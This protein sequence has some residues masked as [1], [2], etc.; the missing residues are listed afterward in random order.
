MK[1]DILG[2]TDQCVDELEVGRQ[3]D[4]AFGLSSWEHVAAFW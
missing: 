4:S 3:S 2:R 1:L